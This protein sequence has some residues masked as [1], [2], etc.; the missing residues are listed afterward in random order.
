MVVVVICNGNAIKVC[1]R[2]CVFVWRLGASLS[3]TVEIDSRL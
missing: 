2:V 1:A 3:R